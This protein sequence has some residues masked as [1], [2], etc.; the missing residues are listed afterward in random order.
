MTG[1]YMLSKEDCC[2]AQM[3]FMHCDLGF[4]SENKN[5]W[6]VYVQCTEGFDGVDV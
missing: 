4:S 2:I 1:M 5:K 6:A 3:A